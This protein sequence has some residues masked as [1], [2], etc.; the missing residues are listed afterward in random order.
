MIKNPEETTATP[1]SPT[2]I[3]SGLRIS[4][5]ILR[6][7]RTAPGE[8]SFLIVKI[9]P[10]APNTSVSL[11][12]DQPH[13][14]QMAVGVN[15]LVFE[16]ELTFTPDISGSY[17]HFRYQPKRVGRHR[18]QLTVETASETV[19]ASLSGRTVLLPDVKVLRQSYQPGS[20]RL[21]GGLVG[22]IGGALIVGL[23]FAGFMYRCE[24]WPQYCESTSVVSTE[25]AVK[26]VAMP[27][28]TEP[29]AD[30]IGVEPL[31]STKS[32]KPQ[33]KKKRSEVASDT[34]ANQITTTEETPT[35]SNRKVDL[36]TELVAPTPTR[37][38]R[39]REERPANKVEKRVQPT[40]TETA[41][42][43]ANKPREK[44]SEESE[45][46]QVLNKEGNN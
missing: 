9:F 12:T 4:K 43:A 32:A 45:L 28:V 2:V 19:T 36:T 13:L 10:P 8:E 44:R 22:L 40:P 6:F 31:K 27:S 46:E 14:F 41:P 30:P 5:S 3:G 23:G 25:P 7:D 26:A 18:G 34:K 37:E 24:L 42:N 15:K 33:S 29:T 11:F 20:Q 38:T 35:V 39:Q 16:P 21:N 1:L 17:V